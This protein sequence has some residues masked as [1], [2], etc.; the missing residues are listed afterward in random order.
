MR[1]QAW[2]GKLVAFAAVMLVSPTALA[3]RPDITV[4]WEPASMAIPTLGT[5]GLVA[6]AVLMAVVRLRLLRSPGQ[7]SRFASTVLIACGVL[8]SVEAI[9]GPILISPPLGIFD[10]DCQGGELEYFPSPTQTLTNTCSNAVRI[11]N[12]EYSLQ[13]ICGALV[14][15]CPVGTLLA[16]E[17]GICTLNHYDFSGCDTE[18]P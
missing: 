12:Y 7:G 16:A 1:K 4:S 2:L 13:P 10:E 3:G 8:F 11:T 17:T 9:T 18:L 14:E 5:Y 15:S 6:A